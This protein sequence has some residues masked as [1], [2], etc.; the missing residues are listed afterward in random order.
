MNWRSKRGRKGWAVDPV[1]DARVGLRERIGG[2]DRLW[3]CFAGVVI[4]LGVIGIA[5]HPARETG[6]VAKAPMVASER[7]LSALERRTFLREFDRITRKRGVPVEAQFEGGRHL[8]LVMANDV[9]MDNLHYLSRT[10]AL[11]LYRRYH[12]DPT[13]STYTNDI[14]TSIPRL[15]A[16]TRWDRFAGDY[17]VKNK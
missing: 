11:V 1:D 6:K 14:K 13:V 7:V 2:N 8:K 3:T 17:S 10:A 4:V 16:V 12:I 9:D 5:Y 15:A